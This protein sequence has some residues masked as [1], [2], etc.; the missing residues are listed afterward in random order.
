MNQQRKASLILALFF[1]IIT[2]NSQDH[3]FFGDMVQFGSRHA[4]F[5]FEQ[6]F[7]TW[8]LPSHLDSGHPPIFGM[9]MAFCWKMFGKS[10]L[11]SHWAMYPFLLLIAF[12]IPRLLKNILQSGSLIFL[13]LLV[14]FEPTLRAQ[15]SLTSPDVVLIAFFCGH[16]CFT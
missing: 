14:F 15:A 1:A 13:S 3:V 16:W 11:V 4:H 6:N 2:F 7:S 8:W 12:A 10:L 5:F 9:Y